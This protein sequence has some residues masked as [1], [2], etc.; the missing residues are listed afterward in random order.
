MTI[1]V[2]AIDNFVAFVVLTSEVE[3]I[4]HIAIPMSEDY[5]Y[6]SSS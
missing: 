1:V 2:V 5:Y 3:R 6:S 4:S